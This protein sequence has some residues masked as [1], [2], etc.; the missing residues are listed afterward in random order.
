MFEAAPTPP[1]VVATVAEPLTCD[2]DIDGV[3]G[4]LSDSES[5]AF[6]ELGNALEPVGCGFEAEVGSS[7]GA[8]ENSILKIG[9]PSKLIFGENPLSHHHHLRLITARASS[10][11]CLEM[12][13]T[14]PQS[15]L[16]S[17]NFTMSE[18][19]RLIGKW[20]RSPSHERP[21]QAECR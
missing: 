17:E 15:S 13:Q 4:R 19:L 14:I 21:L 2:L 5:A 16:Y 1:C 9:L 6:D 10:P 20:K 12:S 8:S 11:N 3:R 7:E 18:W